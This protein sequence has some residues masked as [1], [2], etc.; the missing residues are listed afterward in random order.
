M[1]IFFVDDAFLDAAW[2]SVHD[3]GFSGLSFEEMIEQVGSMSSSSKTAWS[4]SSIKSLG[5]I[6]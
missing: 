3:V 6:F 1:M 5:A 2:R 4:G